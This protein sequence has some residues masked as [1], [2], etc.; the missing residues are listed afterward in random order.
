MTTHI[1]QWHYEYV[2]FTTTQD[3]GR[4]REI[5]NYRIIPDSDSAECYIAETNES[6]PGDEQE[7]HAQLIAAAPTMREAL[8]DI[9]RLAGKSGETGTCTFTLLDLIADYALSALNSA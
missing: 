9:K 3:D 7:A 8:L 4:E 2:P 5:P 6:L 1:I